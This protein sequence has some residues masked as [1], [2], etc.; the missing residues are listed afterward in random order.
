MVN[1]SRSETKRKLSRIGRCE[2]TTTVMTSGDSCAHTNTH[3]STRYRCGEI[4]LPCIRATGPN[5]RARVCWCP[6]TFARWPFGW[7]RSASA[8]WIWARTARSRRR[9]RGRWPSATETQRGKASGAWSRVTTAATAER[10]TR[11]RPLFS[12]H[13]VN[14][15]V[16]VHSPETRGFRGGSANGAADGSARASPALSAK[17]FKFKWSE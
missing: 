2:D 7:W 12:G 17:K 6:A 9:S 14:T 5:R 16:D 8:A 1:K 13:G 11:R 4:R 10:T 3:S 15:I